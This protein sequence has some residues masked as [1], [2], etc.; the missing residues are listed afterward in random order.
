MK[1]LQITLAFFI[2]FN[3][4]FATTLYSQEVIPKIRLGHDDQAGFHRQLL[5]GFDPLS[6]N[7]VDNGFDAKMLD[8]FS[9]DAY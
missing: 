1:I 2:A 6:T 8:V 7:G 3:L 5:L 4:L 9:T